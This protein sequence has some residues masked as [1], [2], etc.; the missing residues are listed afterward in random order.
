MSRTLLHISLAIFAILFVTGCSGRGRVISEA[1]MKELYVD[2]F[3]SDQWLRD[4]IKERSKADTTLFFDPIFERHGVTFEDYERSLDYYLAKPK[5]FTEIVTSVAEMLQQ[6][7][8]RLDEIANMNLK[9]QEE[10]KKLGEYK[11]VDFDPDKIFRKTSGCMAP[12]LVEFKEPEPISPI[13]SGP[14]A[15]KKS[16]SINDARRKMSEKARKNRELEKE[17]LNK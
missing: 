13:V 7:A 8:D 2:M 6:E 4:N 3:I 10:R 11:K 16:A 1:K 9:I 5:T 12:V 15:P 14:V 17:Q